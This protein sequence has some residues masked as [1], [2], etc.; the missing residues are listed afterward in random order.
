MTASSMSSGSNQSC[1]SLRK[2]NNHSPALSSS[3][4]NSLGSSE[5]S[6]AMPVATVSETKDVPTVSL[7]KVVDETVDK[8]KQA[9]NS[10]RRSQRG[11]MSDSDS[12]HSSSSM[13]HLQPNKVSGH[14]KAYNGEKLDTNGAPSHL[15]IQRHLLPSCC[16]ES[17][18]P[19]DLLMIQSDDNLRTTHAQYQPL[20]NLNCWNFNVGHAQVG[21]YL[22][23]SSGS[24]DLGLTYTSLGDGSN[25][26][27]NNYGQ[28]PKRKLT[29]RLANGTN[30]K[31]DTMISKDYFQNLN[32]FYRFWHSEQ[33]QPQHATR[34]IFGPVSFSGIERGAQTAVER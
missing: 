4:N 30:G 10:D 16:Q 1:D 34:S 12:S 3:S 5:F 6:A 27:H 25:S 33:Q 28:Q 29:G 13:K 15:E 21:N 32:F 18:Y 20:Q 8:K 11:C 24:L 23:D 7:N 14:Q 22:Y 31:L 2:S 19:V 17:L 26:Q 9:S